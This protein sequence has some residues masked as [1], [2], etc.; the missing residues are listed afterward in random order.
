MFVFV[1]G[2]KEQLI[3]LSN[4][5]IVLLYSIN[6]VWSNKYSRRNDLRVL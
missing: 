6:G 2:V 3:R 1:F 4:Q 5:R